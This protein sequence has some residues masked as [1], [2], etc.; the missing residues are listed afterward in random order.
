MDEM[1][2]FVGTKANKVWLWLAQDEDTREIVGCAFGDRSSVTAQQLWATLPAVYRQCAF[3]YTDFWEAYAQV[4]PG[5]R[6]KAVGKDSGKTCYIERFKQHTTAT[7]FS[8]GT[9]DT[10]F[11]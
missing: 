10:V 1:R 4:R 9:Q 11:F 2:S 6:Y 7:H 3:I 5:K 8:I